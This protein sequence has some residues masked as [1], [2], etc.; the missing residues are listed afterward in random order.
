ML[1]DD[2]IHDGFRAGGYGAGDVEILT[3]AIRKRIT[4]LAVL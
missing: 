2:Q 3:R 1:T 4:A